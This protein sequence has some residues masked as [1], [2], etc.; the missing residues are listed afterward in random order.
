MIFIDRFNKGM[1]SFPN[2]VV[3]LTTLITCSEYRYRQ[4]KNFAVSKNKEYEY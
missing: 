1:Y 3:A 4:A 2:H